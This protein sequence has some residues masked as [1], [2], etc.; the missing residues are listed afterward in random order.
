MMRVGGKQTTLHLTAH[1]CGSSEKNSITERNRH[2]DVELPSE[3]RSNGIGFD[4]LI[5]EA[6]SVLASGVLGVQRTPGNLNIFD[7]RTTKGSCG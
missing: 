2:I 6:T 3:S 5:V 4:L 1:Y 7:R